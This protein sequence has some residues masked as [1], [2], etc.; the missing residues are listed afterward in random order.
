MRYPVSPFCQN[1]VARI[2]PSRQRRRRRLSPRLEALEDR[3][4]LS[5]LTVTSGADSGT[6]TLRAQIA[7]AK[8]GDTISFA[9]AFDGDTIHL[10]S[11][12]L[13]IGE[14]LSIKGPGAALLDVDA[15]GFSRVFDIT[16]ASVAATISGLTVS[17]GKAEDGG[18]ILDQGGALTLKADTISNDQ[19]IGANPGDSAQGGRCCHRRRTPGRA[20]QHVPVG[21]GPSAVS[22]WARHRLL[23]RPGG[24]GQRRAIS[25]TSGPP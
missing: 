10:T 2:H 5:T 20:G 23:R 8:S 18:G 24:R 9:P 3:I 4:A 12:E 17:G 25:P 1:S 19:A 6:G 13:P 21:P 15:G 7:A 11:G 14:S 22:A 16:S